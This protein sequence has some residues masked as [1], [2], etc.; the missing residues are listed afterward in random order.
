[1]GLQVAP[2]ILCWVIAMVV[3]LFALYLKAKIFRNQV[4][5]NIKHLMCTHI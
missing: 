4:C 1:M 5:C 3:S 2:W